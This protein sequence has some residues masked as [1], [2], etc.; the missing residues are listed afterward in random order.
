MRFTSP[1][2]RPPTQT[3]GKRR[4]D[5][6]GSARPGVTF[7]FPSSGLETKG[8]SHEHVAAP[9]KPENGACP[10][11]PGRGLCT[12]RRV[13]RASLLGIGRARGRLVGL[14]IRLSSLVADLRA[15]IAIRI[16]SLGAPGPVFLASLLVRRRAAG[17]AVPDL[18][19]VVWSNRPR[20]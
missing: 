19:A 7:S 14:G 3:D 5:G 10:S 15:S 2:A 1:A 20:P 8:K 17:R 12:D 11:H 6:G 4:I 13:N 16:G 18:H 9:A